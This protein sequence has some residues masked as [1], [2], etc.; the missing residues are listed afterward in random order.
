MYLIARNPATETY[1]LFDWRKRYIRD[2]VREAFLL[3]SRTDG[4]LRRISASDFY[5]I[6][7]APA[8]KSRQTRF[9]SWIRS[10][11]TAPR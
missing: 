3:M 4:M 2:V 7:K 10:I 11:T 1:Q 6:K 8:R 9:A 5:E